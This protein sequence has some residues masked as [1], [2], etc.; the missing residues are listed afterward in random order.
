M[1]AIIHHLRLPI[2]LYGSACAFFAMAETAPDTTTTAIRND[3]KGTNHI[4]V[5]GNSAQNV[6]VYCGKSGPKR[7]GANV[8]SV[9]V[10]GNSLKGETIIVTDRSSDDVRVD[11]RCDKKDGASGSPVNVNSVTIR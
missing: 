4:V 8:N 9:N 11:H 5:T 6:T 1:K 2:I 7:A 10:D 3:G